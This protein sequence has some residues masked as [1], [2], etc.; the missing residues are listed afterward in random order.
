MSQYFTG[1]ACGE[2]G[3]DLFVLDT[4][5]GRNHGYFV[6]FG[7]MDGRA[8]SNTYILE[9]HF[10]WSGIV[11]ECNPRFWP[12]LDSN[13]SC[14]KD[15]R[16]VYDMTDLELEFVCLGHGFSG[17]ARPGV[18]YDASV[19]T[20]RTVSLNDL[21]H[22][23]GAPQR[24]DYI[25]M[26][27]EGSELA[28]LQTFDWSQWQVAVWTIEHNHQEPARGII[29]EIMTAHGYQRVR[30]DQ[31]QYDDWFVHQSVLSLQ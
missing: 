13:R 20:V 8:Y 6:E 14:H 3:Q 12:E 1:T 21:L 5:Q 31:S 9:K 4:L 22:E 23:H 16:A 2:L 30:E 18:R 11:A 10:A 24:I 25:S 15:D 19:I 29:R 27:T 17:L 7:A 28:I 26:D